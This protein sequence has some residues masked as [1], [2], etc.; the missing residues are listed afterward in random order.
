MDIQVGAVARHGPRQ[1]IHIRTGTALQGQLQ[2]VIRRQSTLVGHFRIEGDGRVTFDSQQAAVTACGCLDDRH[3]KDMAVIR[4]ASGRFYVEPL[5]EQLDARCHDVDQIYV[6][7]DVMAA[8]GHLGA[9]LT[10]V[11]LSHEPQPL[12]VHHA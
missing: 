6:A 8:D 1:A 4:S 3:R 10:S 12:P 5:V 2:T 7:A 9:S 11:V